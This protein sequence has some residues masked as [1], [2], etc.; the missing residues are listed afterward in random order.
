MPSNKRA[1]IKNGRIYYGEEAE[2]VMPNETQARANRED[3]KIRYRGEMLQPSQVDFY[4]KYPEKLKDL[5]DET[6]RLLS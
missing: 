3:M 1:V 6:H 2:I 5:P 4:K